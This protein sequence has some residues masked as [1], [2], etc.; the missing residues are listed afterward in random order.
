MV[1]EKKLS[2]RHLLAT[3]VAF[4]LAL[5]NVSPMAA[6][7]GQAVLKSPNGDL[8][9][10]IAT[11][12]GQDVQ[13]PGGQLAYRVAFRGKPVLVWSNLGLG[14][15]GSPVLGAAVRIES[16]Q[17]SAHDETWKSIAGKANPIRDHYNAIT[18]QTVE[19]TPGGRRM[20]IQA[21]AYDDGVAFRYVVPDQQGGKELRITNEATQFHF[22]KDATT[23]SLVMPDFQTGNEGDYHEI[24]L[25]GLDS[26]LLIGL[27]VL[28]DVPGAAW[29][30][31]T[32][33]DIEDYASLYVYSAGRQNTLAAR[34]APRVEEAAAA[35][36]V[37]WPMDA[38]TNASIV[39][40][41]RQT[42]VTS[43]WRV[44]MIAD[45]PGRLVES[46]MV[47]NLNPP[48][49]IADPS[50]IKP[51][52]TAWD[53]WSGGLVKG[54][55][56]GMNTES[57]KYYIDFA[58]HMGFPYMMIDAGWAGRAA[59]GAPGSAR[60][61]TDLTK[62]NPN[63]DLPALV[64]YAK[65]KNVRL[66]L[67]AHWT[68]VN[69]QVDDAFPLFEKWGIAGVKIDFMDRADQ[70]MVNWYRTI[71]KKAAD[72]H[73]L[74]DYHGAFK[75]DGMRRT[76]PN[77]LT[78]EGVLGAEYDKWSARATPAH[79]VTLAFTRMLA[80]PMD[81]TP[82]GFDNTTRDQF[83]AR[84][85]APQVMGTRAQQAALFV[86][87][88]SAFQMVADH[89][90]AYDGQKETEFLKAVPATWDETRV[91]NGR[92]ARWITMA[93]RSGQEWYVGSITNWDARE[94]DLPL[95]FLGAGSYD[96]EI[97]ADGPNASTDAKDSVVSRRRVDAKTTLK[98]KLAPGGGCA[99]RLTPAR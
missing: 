81:Y 61:A 9:I 72:H 87:F 12:R 59:A 52:K 78:R 11:V 41:I 14:V 99:I 33:A 16:S 46:N 18:V 75:P 57:M 30:G 76:Y 48:S 45:D 95:T 74:I 29:V 25:Q 32:E 17:P 51:G 24:T 28:L 23:W 93:R 4:T 5:I 84:S 71:A 58:S 68:D 92:P 54:V 13:D 96:A 88:E 27:P 64:E 66:W 19:T 8:E 37:P 80:G 65:S 31:L 7:S 2:R 34:L 42:P 62:V 20:T 26:Q 73:L 85:S 3:T 91:I 49:A 43:P 60:P 86:V 77:V 98:L 90:A 69:R 55:R 21:R 39:S 40:V 70:W 10:A 50:W 67:W 53:W 79:R 44:L 1:N 83:I 6:Q 56:G 38:E 63:V 94:V 47:V 36:R 82:G 35:P 22:P 89:P 15:E 97:Y